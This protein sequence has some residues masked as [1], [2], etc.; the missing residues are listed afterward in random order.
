MGTRNRYQHAT[1]RA[2]F[3]SAVS[4]KSDYLTLS[5]QQQTVTTVAKR[6]S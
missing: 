1:E 3:A 6:N 2:K 5:S 4:I